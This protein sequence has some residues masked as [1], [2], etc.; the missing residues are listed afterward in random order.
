[1]KTISEI[2][3]NKE[4][5]Y[6]YV[7]RVDFFRSLSVHS[8]KNKDGVENLLRIHFPSEPSNVLDYRIRAYQPITITFFD[9]IINTV[10]KIFANPLF[11]FEPTERSVK[12]VLYKHF[13]GCSSIFSWIN[14]VGLRSLLTDSNS[15]IVA[16]PNFIWSYID[17]RAKQNVIAPVDNTDI[18]VRIINATDVLVDTERL[19]ILKYFDGY[20]VHSPGEGVSFI[21]K[22]KSKYVE[23]Q[24]FFGALPP[25]NIFVKTKGIPV[26]ESLYQSFIQ[27]V[28]PH[29]NY[30]VILFSD[31]QGAIKQHVY[32]EKWSLGVSECDTC[33]GKGVIEISDFIGEGTNSITKMCPTC[34]GTGN[35]PTGVYSEYRLEKTIFD[36]VKPPFIGYVEKDLEP[37]KLVNEMLLNYLYSGLSAINMEFL[38]DV[39]LNQSGKAKEVD[40]SDINW[41]IIQVATH[42][43]NEVGI[44]LCNWV[45]FCNKNIDYFFLDDSYDY[46]ELNP[47]DYKELEF[48]INIPT[49]INYFGD[50]TLDTSLDALL[51]SRVNVNVKREEELR[52]I[53]AKYKNNKKHKKFLQEIVMLDKLYGYTEQEK[54]AMLN[55]NVIDIDEYRISVLLGRII[56]DILADIKS[57][58]YDLDLSDKYDLI[59]AKYESKY[60]RTTTLP[61]IL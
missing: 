46:V 32:P 53:D 33:G 52:Y 51:S 4:K 13:G 48:D 26:R 24:L 29:W 38:L 34:L 1:M 20:L 16:L 60:K 49:N 45:Y 35:K 12:E 59:K 22:E 11:K 19:V 27:G 2:I 61:T 44:P 55:N 14:S 39:P 30:A 36:T 3:D 37:V 17:M 8:S 31:I 43:V 54:I 57:K 23:K 10:S 40:R 6:N 7:D 21:Y 5:D 56:E 28:V 25:Y 41:F 42:L 58:F 50:N 15:Y 47:I 9:K 18:G